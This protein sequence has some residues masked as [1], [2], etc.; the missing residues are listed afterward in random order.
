M[1]SVNLFVPCAG[2]ERERLEEEYAFVGRQ[3]IR[4][5]GGISVLALPLRKPKKKRP[6]PTNKRRDADKDEEKRPTNREQR[7]KTRS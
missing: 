6:E 5:E 3:T 4:V 7:S 1:K 2:A